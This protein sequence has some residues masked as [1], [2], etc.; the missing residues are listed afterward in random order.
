MGLAVTLAQSVGGRFQLLSRRAGDRSALRGG[1]HPQLLPGGRRVE[2]GGERGELER[3]WGRSVPAS[4]G[5]DAR[6]IL[7]AAARRELEVLYLIGVDPLTDA[8]DA[9]LARQA[10]Q[11]VSFLVVQDISLGVYRDVADAVLP[12][13]AYLERAGHLS[14]WE[15]RSQRIDIVRPAPGLARPDWQ[16]FQELSEVAGADLGF[17]SVEDVQAEMAPLLKS[18]RVAIEAG[19]S[20]REPASDGE[21]FTLFTY[22]LLVDEG[23]QLDGAEELKAALGL[24]AFVQ[25]H[26]EDASRLGIDD[27]AVVR[28]RTEHGQAELPAKVGVG[29]SVGAAFV[30]WNQPGLQANTLFADGL[31]AAATIEPAGEREEVAS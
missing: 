30:P 20:R 17:G 15:G 8:P 25:L 10:V 9:G 19:P 2:D 5:R 16:I 4:A 21:G 6:G 11:N 7:E 27:G 29:I 14:D 13:A 22:P 31:R 24:D 12:A 26:R 28:V 3:A 18:R 1:V 23:L